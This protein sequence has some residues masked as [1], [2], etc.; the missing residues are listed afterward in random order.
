MEIPKSR[1]MSFREHSDTVMIRGRQR[2]TFFCIPR[3]AYQRL[4]FSFLRNVGAASIS[5]SRS[6][7]MGW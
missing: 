5:A 1:L 3:K 7:V 4:T 2:D 6:T